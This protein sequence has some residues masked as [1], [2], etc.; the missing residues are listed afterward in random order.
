MGSSRDTADLTP[1]LCPPSGL[2]HLHHTISASFHCIWIFRIAWTQMKHFLHV[3][4]NRAYITPIVSGIVISKT[5]DRYG[6]VRVWNL[7]SMKQTGSEVIHED[8]R[9]NWKEAHLL[10]PYLPYSS[11]LKKEEEKT[12]E[13]SADNNRVT[14][15]ISLNPHEFWCWKDCKQRVWTFRSRRES[16]GT[17][18]E[19]ACLYIE[20]DVLVKLC[21][22]EVS[23]TNLGLIAGYSNRVL[24]FLTPSDVVY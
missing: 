5:Q 18:H 11:N 22:W 14:A 10:I 6:F 19:T 3:L 7:V 12:S 9:K 20:S 4:F 24:V 17:D 21:I 23:G 2:V 15:V 1:N 16:R 8:G 13:T